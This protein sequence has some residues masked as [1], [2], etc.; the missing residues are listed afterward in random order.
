MPAS[1]AISLRTESSSVSPTH[2]TVKLLS[3]TV[4]HY[5]NMSSP[6]TCLHE[7]GNACVHSPRILRLT[8]QQGFFV[9]LIRYPR[10]CHREHWWIVINFPRIT[11]FRTHPSGTRC[12]SSQRTSTTRT[13]VHFLIPV[14]ERKCLPLNLYELRSNHI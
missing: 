1:S 4:A 11:R 13:K 9:C 2:Y 7:T 3:K 14:Q 5:E 6:F 12:I 8:N 10:Y